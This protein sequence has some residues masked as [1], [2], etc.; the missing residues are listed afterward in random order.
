VKA[1]KR[2]ER[3]ANRSRP[4][5]AASCLQGFDLHPAFKLNKGMELQAAVKPFGLLPAE[6]PVLEGLGYMMCPAT[7]CKSAQ[8][9]VWPHTYPWGG[10][11]LRLLSMLR[12]QQVDKAGC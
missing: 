11:G 6:S 3:Q 2:L 5:A 1:A 9:G 12:E 10:V 7:A 4:V 8:V